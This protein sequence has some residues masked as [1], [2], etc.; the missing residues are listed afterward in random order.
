MLTVTTNSGYKIHILDR[1]F[2]GFGQAKF[3]YGGLVLGSSLFTI[4]PLLPL[5]LLLN[6][7]VVRIDSNNHPAALI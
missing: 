1:A 2:H 7:K 6:K 4:L 5:K 3:A